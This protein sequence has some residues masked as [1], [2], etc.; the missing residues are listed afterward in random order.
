[1]K[2]YIASRTKNKDLV[3]NIKQKLESKGHEVTFDWTQI[4]I[5]TPYEENIEKCQEVATNITKA[6]ENTDNFILLSDAAGTDM[7]VELGLA[8]THAKN[9][10]IL[11]DHNKRSL[12]HLHPKITHINTFEELIY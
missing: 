4:S 7:F 9:I 6:I 5:L 10:Y 11:G 8:L 1:M 2:W 12:M 3:K